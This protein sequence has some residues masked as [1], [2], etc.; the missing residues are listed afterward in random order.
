MNC[1]YW[2]RVIL[3]LYR[4]NRTDRNLWLYKFLL[5]ILVQHWSMGLAATCKTPNKSDGLPTLSAIL[6]LDKHE[7]PKKQKEYRWKATWTVPWNILNFSI[8]NFSADCE[9]SS[10]IFLNLLSSGIRFFFFSLSKNIL[11]LLETAIVTTVEAVVRTI[12]K[13]LV[14]PYQ[15]WFDLYIFTYLGNIPDCNLAYYSSNSIVFI[16]CISKDKCELA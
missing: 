14:A 10:N 5:S 11:E 3:F 4:L 1:I 15:N 13:Q 8:G 9:V 16:K 12:Q 6:V 2:N 7:Q